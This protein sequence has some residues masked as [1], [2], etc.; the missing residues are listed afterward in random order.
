MATST[1]EFR[2]WIRIIVI[3]ITISVV[4]Q[5]IWSNFQNITISRRS[6]C[7]SKLVPDVV[8][9]VITCPP[10]LELI[11][12]HLL[13]ERYQTKEV[14]Y[15]VDPLPVE[16]WSDDRGGPILPE[17]K[18][19]VPLLT[20]S[21]DQRRKELETEAI[22]ALNAAVSSRKKG[23]MRRAETIIEHALA[24]APN[25][26]DIL[27][28]YGI[29]IETTRKNLVEA[30][31]LYTRAL[32]YDPH[33][34][35][36]LTRRARTL[37]LVE[38]IDKN[39]LKELRR[40]RAYF[41][42]IPR[43]NSALKRAMRESYFKHVY[44]TVAIE[45]NTMTLMQTRSILETR[46]AVAGKSIMEHNEILGMDA[47]LRFLNH[48]LVHIGRLTVDDLLAIHRRVLGFVD[49]EAAGVFRTTQVYVGSFT[50]TA[51]ELVPDEMEELVMWLND[52]ETL[53]L[54]PIEFAAI[55]HYKFVYIHPFVDGNG[56]TAR[57][58]MNLIL[59]QAGYPPIIIPVEER[60][61]Y[62][63]TLTAANGGDLRPFIRFIAKQTDA[64]LQ[65]RRSDSSLRFIS[66][67]T[68]LKIFCSELVVTAVLRRFI[69]E[70][71]DMVSPSKDSRNREMIN[72][73]NSRKSNLQNII[74]SV[75]D[76]FS[77]TR[78]SL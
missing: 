10:S 16:P 15:F 35:E 18:L 66:S 45:G 7:H 67:L 56:R 8:R 19:A 69:H 73:M 46:M 34:T 14:G 71:I 74:P 54:D 58:L 12:G 1:N 76:S 9:T 50:P 55:A 30:E 23:N 24:L 4:V 57:L 72:V 13:E 42:R 49:P 63:H 37:P 70:L 53:L 26:P 6:L 29:I 60:S 62:Y 75:Q 17:E 32:S 59:M 5:V 40:K 78:N 41:L 65:V 61:E 47:A 3:S 21:P 28:E 43:N 52:E 51:P 22:A 11:H 68:S 31:Q 64:T 77:N 27:T 38:E 20:R 36:A 44:H 39:M 2:M 33:H 25:H 48:S